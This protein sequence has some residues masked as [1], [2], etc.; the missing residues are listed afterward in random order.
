MEHFCYDD[1]GRVRPRSLKAVPA[2]MEFT[3]QGLL[4][5]DQLKGGFAGRFREQALVAELHAKDRLN[6]FATGEVP[7]V[8]EGQPDLVKV[9]GW[10]RARTEEVM[11]EVRPFAII[12]HEHVDITVEE[13]NVRLFLLRQ[14]QRRVRSRKSISGVRAIVCAGD[15]TRAKL[16]L[17]LGFRHESA[18]VKNG[19]V[20]LWRPPYRR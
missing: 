7:L 6:I 15:E 1:D 14:L 2:R 20:L 5:L 16:L 10:L 12:E 8:F 17:S 9:I 18:S 3:Q 19:D 13:E 4:Q 11:S